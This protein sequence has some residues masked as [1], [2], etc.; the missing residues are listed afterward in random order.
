[1]A[2]GVD[3]ETWLHH[4]GNADYSRWFREGIKDDELAAEAETIESRPNLSAD[5]TRA[6][7]REAIEKRYTLPSEAASGVEEKSS[8][9]PNEPSNSGTQAG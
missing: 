5:E 8:T 2:D 9:T 3:D 6:A 1:M 7:I 4:L